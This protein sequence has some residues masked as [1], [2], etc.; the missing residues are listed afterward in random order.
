MPA[1]PLHPLYELLV[2]P[3]RRDPAAPCRIRDKSSCAQA[4]GFRPRPSPDRRGNHAAAWWC[5][6]C[7]PYPSYS[8]RPERGA[9]IALRACPFRAQAGEPVRPLPKILRPEVRLRA[10]SRCVNRRPAIWMGHLLFAKHGLPPIAT[11]TDFFV[12]SRGPGGTFLGYLSCGQATLVVVAAVV[13]PS[14]AVPNRITAP[15]IATVTANEDVLAMMESVG[16]DMFVEAVP[17]TRHCL[18]AT[19]GLSGAHASAMAA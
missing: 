19:T 16:H 12:G 10:R 4:G 17:R 11:V 18:E 6:R 5:E 1:L 13:H 3:D 9:G 14:V 2:A 8:Y 7:R 15:V